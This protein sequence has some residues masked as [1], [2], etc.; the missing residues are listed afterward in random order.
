M[1]SRWVRLSS[2][3]QDAGLLLQLFQF[4]ADGARLALVFL[5]LL[6]AASGVGLF[7]QVLRLAVERAHA[8]DGLVDAVNQALAFVIGEA[9]LAAPRATPSRWRAPAQCGSGDIPWAAS[10]ARPRR[11]SPAPARPFCRPWRG[12]QFC[13]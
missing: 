10:S 3:K 8:V 1:I 5:A 2:W 4:G 12:R 13:R 7:F 6:L 9:Q 11:I